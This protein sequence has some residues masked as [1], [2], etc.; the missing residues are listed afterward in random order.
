M[1]TFDTDDL[2][3]TPSTEAI[4]TAARFAPSVDVPVMTEAANRALLDA[5]H[6]IEQRLNAASI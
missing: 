6:D 5:I 3:A 2:S 4:V 1:D